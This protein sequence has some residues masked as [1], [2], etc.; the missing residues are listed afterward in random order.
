M[1]DIIALIV[2]VISGLIL[3]V[4]IIRKFS[5]LVALDVNTIPQEIQERKKEDIVEMRLR[6][7]LETAKNGFL[8]VWT[9]LAKFVT[10]MA[11]RF[12]QKVMELEK[13]YQENAES[14]TEAVE[15]NQQK[16]I[17]LLG[18]SEELVK[19]EDLQAAEKKLIEVISLDHR[20][21]EAYKKLGAVYISLKDHEHAIESLQYALKLDEKDAAV[22]DEIAQVYA[23]LGDKEKALMYIKEAVKH[24]PKNPK[25]IDA[26][27][28]K[29]IEAGDKFSAEQALRKLKKVNPENQKIDEYRQTISEMKY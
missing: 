4:M 29:S 16:V 27:I 19:G 9:P 5:V 10:S 7:K 3:A 6:R 23:I 20:S 13:K 28:E 15:I 17:S 2:F 22:Y 18:E 26:W 25:Y 11:S 12:Y 24:D 8:K 14:V 1:I 21:I